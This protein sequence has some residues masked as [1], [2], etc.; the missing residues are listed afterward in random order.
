MTSI[1]DI[2]KPKSL[3]ELTEAVKKM[4]PFDFVDKFRRRSIKGMKVGFKKQITYFLAVTYIKHFSKIY[5]PIWGTWV[6]LMI[7]TWIWKEFQ[8][9]N[10]VEDI[11]NWII[12]GSLLPTMI[13]A[14]LNL[15][16]TRWVEK[17]RVQE[18]A[19]EIRR[20]SVEIRRQIEE[21]E[22][23]LRQRQHDLDVLRG[24]LRNL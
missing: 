4:H 23:Q 19:N 15:Y 9:L 11:F 10:T 24:N 13:S 8:L 18:E 1:S 5:W 12:I 2:L 22:R 6:I 17:R 20:Q 21:H 3:D 16:I 7:C 14:C